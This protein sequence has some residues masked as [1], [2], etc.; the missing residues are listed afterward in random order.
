MK[1]RSENKYI[2]IKKKTDIV[3]LETLDNEDKFVAYENYY[4]NVTEEE[5]IKE[6]LNENL[7]RKTVSLNLLLIHP[8]YENLKL[9]KSFISFMFK[10]N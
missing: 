5:T 1:K 2:P 8:F 3:N 4:S 10:N 9:D 6:E 7:P